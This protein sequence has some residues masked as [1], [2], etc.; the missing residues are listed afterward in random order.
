MRPN[1]QPRSIDWEDNIGVLDGEPSVPQGSGE[2]EWENAAVIGVNK[3]PPTSWRHYDPAYVSCLNGSWKF[4]WSPSPAGAP[5]GF[6]T[7]DFQ[8]VDWPTIP[9]P[10]HWE[11]NGYGIPIYTNVQYPFKPTPPMVPHEDNPTGCY[12]HEFT[13]PEEWAGRRIYLS[14]RGVDCCFY[15]W[16]N[17]HYVGFSKV[18]R[19]P[20]EFDIT[21]WVGPGSNLIAVKELRWSD[22]TYLED[23]DM[24]WLSGIFRDV[25]IHALPEQHIDDFEITSRLDDEYRDA[26]LDI[27]V[28]LSRPELPHRLHVTL[29]D[30]DRVIASGE[31]LSFR[32]ENP[33]KWNAETPHLYRLEIDLRTV[34]GALLDRV[35]WKLGFRSVEIRD[36]QFLVNGQ[37][38]LLL[39]V[40]RHEF[41]CRTGRVI[42]EADMLEDIRL[43]KSHNLNAVRTSHYPN[44]SRWYELCDQYGL[45][46]IDEVDLETHGLMDT[47]SRDPAWLPA[48]MDRLE[49]MVERDKNHAC[50][51]IW[52]L[53][54][55]S[56]FGSNFTEMSRWLKHR[57]PSRPVNYFHAG[58]DACV[59]IVGLHY[60]SLESVRGTLDS[61]TSGRPILLEEYA[62]SMGNSTGNMREYLDL[63]ESHPRLIGGF[64]WDWIDQT[65]ER[66]TPEGQTWFAYGGDFGDQPNDGKFCMNGLLFSDR[67]P[68]PKLFDLRHAFQ[69]F[70]ITIKPDGKATIRNRYSFR[71]LSEFRVVW[72]WQKMGDVVKQ[73][74]LSQAALQ[75]GATT[76]MAL[77]VPS[78][79]LDAMCLNL[80]ICDGES[81]VA[82]EQ[83]ML[84]PPAMTF[85]E[86]GISPDSQAETLVFEASK[87]TAKFSNGLLKSFVFSGTELLVL[88]PEPQFYRAPTLND[89]PFLSAWVDAGLDR[90][91]MSKPDACLIGN[92][93]VVE[94]SA[95]NQAGLV[96]AHTLTTWQ[97]DAEGRLLVEFKVE[98]SN[99]APALPRCGFSL[100]CPTNFNA[101]SW[102]GRGPFET[103]RDRKLGARLGQWE[104]TVDELFVPYPVPQENGNLTDVYSA[105]LSD[106]RGFGL[107]IE[108]D[109]PFET[110]AHYY[111]VS[112]LVKAEHLHELQRRPYIVWNIDLGQAGVGNGSH[113]PGT[114]PPYQLTAKK[115][116]GRFRLSPQ[117]AR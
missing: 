58:T 94:Q 5:D 63:F 86:N 65:L 16:L 29:K 66:T 78:R 108:S 36:G 47:L 28:S 59:D 103:Y 22:A 17:G 25:V 53:G 73:G 26:E 56:G 8:D 99:Q 83:L 91:S 107:K 60:P 54:N 41:N 110:S 77:P 71:D 7:L 46:V 39:G 67:T 27:A 79:A 52:S 64:I 113:G 21:D 75:P 35:D 97:M 20:A 38:V 106:K 2:A 70:A 6:Q 111:T 10:G 114:L 101:F 96:L 85:P 40:N 80:S 84:A 30:G 23:Q 95:T 105:K 42:S 50:I 92:R 31:Q 57:D 18:S 45:Y 43:I 48:Y 62:H 98:I 1:K 100:K 93:L 44:Q 9:V 117:P 55:E 37:S 115:M 12:R 112:D 24:W 4:H 104:A 32:I 49:R 116:R 81:E 76:E 19:C 82:T 34:E 102:F 61:E 88:P 3:L 90:L 68:Q 15:L 33:K 72:Q 13:V 11:L 69:P 87:S 14:F 74:E 89:R 51:V 109:S